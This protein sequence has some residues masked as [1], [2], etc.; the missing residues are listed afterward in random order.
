MSIH[1]GL[2]FARVRP[3]TSVTVALAALWLAARTSCPP[4]RA[5]TT[6]VPPA[7]QRLEGPQATLAT[8]AEAYRRLSPDDVVSH[9]TADYR[10]H[11]LGDSLVRFVSGFGREQEANTIRNMLHGLVRGADTLMAPVDSVG[12]EMDGFLEAPDPEHPDSTQHYRVVVVARFG[13]GIRSLGERMLSVSSQHVF[14]LVRGDVALLV[15]GQPAGADRWYIRRWLEDVAGVRERLERE[16]GEC[17]DPAAPA[18]GP[19]SGAGPPVAVT[20]LAIRPL[21][22]PAC[23]RLEVTCDLPGAEPARVEVYDVAGRLVNRRDVPVAAAGRV[24]VEAGAGTSLRPGVYWV[25][26]GQ[27][28]RRPS[29]RM[30]VVA[31]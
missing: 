26:L 8:F 6:S 7:S 12:M 27:A 22:N 25:R 9:F 18:V 15:E 30:V 20:A 29:T 16:R 28:V 31:R 1:P 17:G 24:T 13:F 14:H 23:A 21:L 2:R 10:F 19:R 4:A 5:G 3:L 11:I